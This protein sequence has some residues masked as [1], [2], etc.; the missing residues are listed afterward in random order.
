M[1]AASRPFALS[2]K[3]RPIRRAERCR[4]PRRWRARCSGKRSGTSC[5]PAAAKPKSWRSAAA[6]RRVGKGALAPCPP[7]LFRTRIDGGHTAG[8]VASVCF[9]HPTHFAILDP[10]AAISLETHQATTA[11]SARPALSSAPRRR[12][13]KMSPAAIRNRR[14]APRTSARLDPACRSPVPTTPPAPAAVHR[15]A[16]AATGRTRARSV[17]IAVSPPDAR[18]RL[19]VLPVRGHVRAGL[20]EMDVLIDMVDPGYRNEMMVRAVRRALFGQLDLV[21][22]F[23]MIDLSDGLPVG[24]NDVHVLFDLRRIGHC[25]APDWDCCRTK[26]RRSRKRSPDA[27]Q[28]VA[29]AKRCAAEPGS[30]YLR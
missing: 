15:P 17:R 28:R 6:N 26:R 13:H 10:S 7:S 4:T 5:R 19:T 23:Q 2:V 20:V 30:R 3:T 12:R 14:I 11:R 16:P 22:P 24:R 21:G 27:A 25:A 8:R 9:A 1:T 18:S 29:L